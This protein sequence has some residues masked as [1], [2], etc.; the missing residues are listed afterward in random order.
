MISFR[1]PC[2]E[3]LTVESKHAGTVVMCPTCQGRVTASAGSSAV[4]WSARSRRGGQSSY[5]RRVALQARFDFGRHTRIAGIALGVLMLA[6][7]VIPMPRAG[8]TMQMLCKM[9]GVVGST[10]GML[11]LV[12][13][14]WVAGG[15]A[16]AAAMLPAGLKRSVALLVVAGLAVGLPI[17]AL[18]SA[19]NEVTALR[20]FV[21]QFRKIKSLYALGAGVSIFALL[22]VGHARLQVGGGPA[23]RI[24]QGIFA[25]VMVT[26]FGI[27]TVKAFGQASHAARAS[28]DAAIIGF[29]VQI[30][31]WIISILLSCISLL[32]AGLAA[33]ANAC[34]PKMSRGL[35]ATSLLLIYIPLGMVVV[36]AI[37]IPWRAGGVEGLA[38]GSLV[39]FLVLPRFLLGSLA[40][41]ALV[42]AC[43]RAR[44]DRV[45]DQGLEVL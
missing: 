15:G 38:A 26:V 13:G 19:P 45:E 5:R 40:G 37:G 44:L 4:D 18:L 23:V 9:R 7:M 34:L 3:R 10:P 29:K 30:W 27:L 42:A 6:T 35:A 28:Q 21:S 41:A 14:T 25:A 11:L 1:C 17:V 39:C 31:V 12:L 36:L 2:G 33:L 16:I 43:V 22:A 24:C 8:M 20:E 32:V